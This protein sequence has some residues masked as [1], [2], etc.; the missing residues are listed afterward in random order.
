[1][2][3]PGNTGPWADI[4]AMQKRFNDELAA[5]KSHVHEIDKRAANSLRMRED[6]LVTLTYHHAELTARDCATLQRRFDEA[7]VAEIAKSKTARSA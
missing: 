4:D 6:G 3:E 7:V 5:L 1:M 2:S